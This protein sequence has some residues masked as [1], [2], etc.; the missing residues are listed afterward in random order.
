[1][2]SERSI[3]TTGGARYRLLFRIASGG[4]GSV[5]LA[6]QHGAAGFRRV[7]AIKRAFPHLLE[8]TDIRRLMA[9][10]IRLSSLVRHPNVVAISDVDDA[11]GEL[12]L[13]MEYVEGA[14][15]AELMRHGL[16]QPLGMRMVLDAAEGLQ[17][18][19][20]CT[21]ESSQPLGLVHRDISPQNILVGVDGV[22]RIADFGIAQ[23]RDRTGATVSGLIRGK[24]SYLAPEYIDT[25][26]ATPSSDVFA[27]AI[28]AWEV[29]TQRRLFRGV[30]D[31]DTIARV[32]AAKV[33]APSR[34]VPGIPAAI[35]AV[36]LRALALKP[37][38]RYPTAHAFGEALEAA[39]RDSALLARRGLVAEFVRKAVGPTLT[40][41]RTLV[42]QATA[43]VAPAAGAP[44]AGAPPSVPVQRVPVP[45]TSEADI[46][47]VLPGAGDAAVPSTKIIVAPPIALASQLGIGITL[48]AGLTLIVAASLGAMNAAS[49]VRHTRNARSASIE[50]A[51]LDTGSGDTNIARFNG[52]VVADVGPSARTTIDDRVH[53]P[54]DEATAVLPPSK[55]SSARRSRGTSRADEQPSSSPLERWL[56][57]RPRD[58]ATSLLS[59]PPTKAPTNPYAK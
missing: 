32:R 59:A 49:A 22:A 8:D 3:E 45:R 19:H 51:A 27:L 55:P 46:P 42:Q 10:E 12:S 57:A 5:Y 24:P 36:L 53:A 26:F 6:T 18:V 40:E 20:D 7:V 25:S 1:M 39:L 52:R 23:A 38:D 28:V 29:L 34:L 33:E 47:V 58:S 37:E 4:M 2:H 11:D 21:D 31:V 13:I 16:P 41:R 54:P 48:V 30:N 50:A 56:D 44:V 17:A 15:L 43:I 9:S 14:S 35:D